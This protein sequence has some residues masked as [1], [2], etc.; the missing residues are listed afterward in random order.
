MSAADTSTSSFNS[1]RVPPLMKIT[2]NQFQG[3]H[4][5]LE[6]EAIF[7]CNVVFYCARSLI[8]LIQSV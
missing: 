4:W 3:L 1:D 5:V 7:S 8:P 6:A 2:C